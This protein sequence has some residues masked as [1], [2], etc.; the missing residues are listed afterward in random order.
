MVSCSIHLPHQGEVLFSCFIWRFDW[1]FVLLQAEMR[2]QRFRNRVAWALLSVFVPM[3]ML[4][5]MHIHQP[6]VDETASCVECAHHVNHP[7]HFTS[8]VEHLDDCVLCQFLSLVYTPAAVIQAVTFVALTTMV[9]LSS[10]SAVCSK[11]YH[12]QSPRAPPFML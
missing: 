5:A 8:A 6:A 3:M 2:R 9:S 1:K 7:G 10:I 12:S 11:V 4:S